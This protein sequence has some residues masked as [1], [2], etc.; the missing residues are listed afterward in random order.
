MSHNPI[1]TVRPVDHPEPPSRPIRSVL[2][3]TGLSLVVTSIGS[4]LAELMAPSPTSC[5]AACRWCWSCSC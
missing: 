3:L 2:A 5:C 1:A 4:V